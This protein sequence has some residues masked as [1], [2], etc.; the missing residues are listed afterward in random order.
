MDIFLFNYLL[1]MTFLSLYFNRHAK[2]IDVKGNS[3]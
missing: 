2:S 3:V 1:P